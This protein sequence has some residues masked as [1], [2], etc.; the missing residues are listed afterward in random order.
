MQV[1]SDGRSIVKRKVDW[2][3]ILLLILIPIGLYVATWNMNLDRPY[4]YTDIDYHKPLE[5]PIAIQEGLPMTIEVR[6]TSFWPDDGTGSG[7][8]TASGLSIDDFQTNERGWYIHQGK[9][10]LGAATY[11]CLNATTGACGKYNELPAGY[12]I[13]NLYDEVTI[14]IE[15]NY[16]D[17][18]ILDACGASFWDEEYQRYDIFVVDE[19]SATDQLGHV[20]LERE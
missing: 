19:K 3:L 7:E 18:I 16:Y 14:F 5:M 20:A 17:A 11:G 1:W 2:E 6:F 8:V 9:V 10:V 12:S 13:H 15:G 4:K